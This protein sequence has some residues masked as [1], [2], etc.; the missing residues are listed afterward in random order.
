M[1]VETK[2]QAELQSLMSSLG[3]WIN[4]G[5]RQDAAE[6]AKD[7]AKG[8]QEGIEKGLG[9]DGSPMPPLR[10]ATVEGAVR[11]EG[12]LRNRSDFGNTPMHATGKTASSITSKKVA[13]D[14]WEI[15]SNSAHGNMVLSSNAKGGGNGSPFAG[16][17]RKAVRDPLQVT[18]KQMDTMEDAL[19][20]GLDKALNG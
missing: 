15:S 14:T 1:G 20:K 5:S 19:L 8:V 10:K 4:N 7:I 9:A 12:D 17:V 11:R 6:G 16:D 13:S 2:G 3:G 18:D